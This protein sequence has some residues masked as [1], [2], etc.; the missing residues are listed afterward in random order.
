MMMRFDKY[1]L[2]II[3]QHIFLFFKLKIIYINSFS[4]S[5]GFFYPNWKK[6]FRFWTKINVQNG[7]PKS[8]F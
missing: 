5:S 2:S 4:A 3:N 6:I 8:R 7:K 1:N